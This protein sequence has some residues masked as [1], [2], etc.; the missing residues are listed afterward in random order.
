MH[1]LKRIGDNCDCV[2]A[3]P[4]PHQSSCVPVGKKDP[5]TPPQANFNFTS[6]NSV[7]DS[8]ANELWTVLVCKPWLDGEF[9]TTAYAVGKGKPT[10]VNTYGRQLLW[11]QAIA[12][13][14]KPTKPAA[15]GRS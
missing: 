5:Q 6:G 2:S 15:A 11:S 1:C 3:S 9:G 4:A 7:V 13:D 14:E 12:A 10:V 8:N